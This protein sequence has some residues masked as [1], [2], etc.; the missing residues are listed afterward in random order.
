MINRLSYHSFGKYD[1][2]LLN[3]S[4]IEVRMG[5]FFSARPG[6]LE[7]SIGPARSARWAR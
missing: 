6:P 1:N 7:K 2:Q 5:R 4:K 3:R